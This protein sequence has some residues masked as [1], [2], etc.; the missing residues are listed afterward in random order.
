M[1]YSG[2]CVTTK[3][4]SSSLIVHAIGFS[5]SVRTDPSARSPDRGSDLV[6][7]VR[8]RRRT[9]LRDGARRDR[10]RA[11]G[12]HAS[13]CGPAPC[14]ASSACSTGP[15]AGSR[16]SAG[17]TGSVASASAASC[18]GRR[19][20]HADARPAQLGEVLAV[21]VRQ[22]GGE[23][24]GVSRRVADRGL[25]VGREPLPGGRRG[26]EG[27]DA[28]EQR[29][30]RD[31]LGVLRRSRSRTRRAARSRRRR[32]G[33]RGAGQHVVARDRLNRAGAEAAQDRGRG[34]VVSDADRQAAEG[35]RRRQRPDREDAA[36]LRRDEAER[37]HARL[38]ER[39]R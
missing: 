37:D 22:R 34:V 27:V 13:T 35:V 11:V 28:V 39:R 6:G 38:L 30:A 12:G 18:S 7:P 24:D 23:A 21:P 33:R 15:V 19:R 9:R 14:V 29:V 8:D 1:P 31:V 32:G 4:P 10:L 16:R 5:H 17:R 20:R 36:Q 26:D 25:L 2:C 3:R